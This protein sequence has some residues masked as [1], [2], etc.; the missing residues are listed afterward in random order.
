MNAE[1]IAATAQQLVGTQFAQTQTALPTDAPLPTETVAPTSTT[2][3][4]PLATLT[5]TP[6]ASVTQIAVTWAPY[7]AD[8][9]AFETAQA[10][11]SS[12]NTPLLLDNR[13]GERI[14]FIL[15]SPRYQ[16]YT[17]SDSRG[18]A[19]PQ[20]QYSYRAWIG[21]EGPFSGSFVLNNPDKHVLIFYPDKIHFST[22]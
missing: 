14:M 8:P 5:E 10:D 17:F 16:E 9:G 21:D 18:I 6:S 1:Q 13:S 7:G 3:S 12:G 20:G 22:P 19:L 11:K 2:T 15:V 4:T